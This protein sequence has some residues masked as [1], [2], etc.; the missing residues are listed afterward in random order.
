ME[1]LINNR[2]RRTH[3]R[4]LWCCERVCDREKERK[5]IKK[6]RKERK[7]VRVFPCWSGKY[8]WRLFIVMIVSGAC[9]VFIALFVAGL[10]PGFSLSLNESRI[11]NSHSYQQVLN[12]GVTP[13][14]Q[15]KERPVHELSWGHSGTKV[16]CESCLFSQG[17]TPGFTEMGELH[18]VFVLALSL[19][20][21]AGAT[22]DKRGSLNVGAWNPQESGRKAPLSC[23]V[24]FAML[25]CSFSLAAAQLF[26]VL[27]KM[28]SAVQK[29]QCCSATSAAQHSE[30]CS[31]TSVSLVACCRGGV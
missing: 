3:L 17:K 6:E 13:A 9:G 14:N 28:T 22:P 23:N 16:R 20:W 1:K 19:V 29:S 27:A 10:D 12:S 18:E 21:S 2:H 26:K 31:A 30:N 7:K 24:A 11:S 5:E 25:R 15:T 8:Q 4:S